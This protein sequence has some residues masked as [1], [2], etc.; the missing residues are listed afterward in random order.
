ME[1]I[2]KYFK[3][4]SSEQVNQFGK[5]YE[6]YSYWNERINLISRKDIQNFYLHHVLH[7]LAIAKVIRFSNETEIMDAGTGGGF[8]GIPLSIYFPKVQFHLIDSIGK[9]IKVVNQIIKTLNLNNVYA[10][11]ARIEKI[12]NCYDFI[13]SR[14]VSSLP[15]FLPLVK[16]NFKVESKNQLNN[17]ILYLKG[18]IFT[19]E[20]KQINKDVKIYQLI[21]YFKEDYFKTKSLIH[22]KMT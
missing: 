17:G 10:E 5:L 21:E 11:Q 14:A 20:L 7:S 8:P 22:I 2:A 4:L 19:D 1:I 3:D 18:G 13:I 6:L 16:N 12:N 9:K 15:K